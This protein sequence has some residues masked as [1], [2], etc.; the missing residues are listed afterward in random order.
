MEFLNNIH[1]K[2]LFFVNLLLIALIIEHLYLKL[3]SFRKNSSLDRILNSIKL[4][5]NKK[6]LSINEKGVLFDVFY[7]CIDAYVF[8]ICG[9]LGIVFGF[10]FIGI[11]SK[12][13]DPIFSIQIFPLIDLGNLNIDP[14]MNYLII[15]LLEDLIGYFAHYLTHVVPFLWKYHRFHHSAQSFCVLTARRAAIGDLLFIQFCVGIG[16]KIFF[17]MPP[18]ETILIMLAIKTFVSMFAHSDLPWDFGIFGNILVSPRFHKFHHASNSEHLDK[19][20]GMLFSFWDIIFGTVS[21]EYIKDK[22]LADRI[23]L[24]LA[25]EKPIDY[26]FKTFIQSAFPD[27]TFL[28]K[29]LKNFF[30]TI[31][32]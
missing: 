25:H 7:F 27:F 2:Q 31:N 20:F 24:G 16:F 19:N 17:K 8:Y 26:S 12:L 15:Y 28:I 9:I 5:L 3:V 18:Y 10:S 23:D 6:P 1:L 29:N 11:L 21:E 4:F 32:I 30:L 22:S 14:R 13:I